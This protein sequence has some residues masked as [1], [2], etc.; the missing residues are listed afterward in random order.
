M[1]R[2]RIQRVL[3]FVLA[4]LLIFGLSGCDFMISSLANSNQSFAEV[5]ELE[6][7][8]HLRYASQ[9][10]I[11]SMLKHGTGVVFFT[12]A[13]CP[14][15]H[16]YVKILD[17]VSREY[18][19]EIL[20]YDIY[21]DREGD[22]DFYRTVCSLLEEKLMETN[23]FDASGNVRIYVPEVCFVSSGEIFAHDNESSL[24]SGEKSPEFYWNSIMEG[25]TVSH[26]E[27]LSKRLSTY[28]CRVCKDLSV[29][30]SRGCQS[31]KAQI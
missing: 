23:S 20:C 16:T 19:I 7:S 10:E 27:N 21:D 15:C 31:C 17:A 2:K 13:G 12:W 4:F 3:C 26:A 25:D 8:T 5:Y 9:D 18:D 1:K 30:Q 11:L 6:S 14:W 29:I 22:T 24:F 28:F